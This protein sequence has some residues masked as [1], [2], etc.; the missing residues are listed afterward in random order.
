[1]NATHPILFR[2]VQR[3]RD[4]WWIMLLVFGLAALQWSIFL[5]HLLGA[6][7]GN[8]PAPLATT[9]VFWLLFGVGLPWF[10]LVLR[11]EVEVYPDA[12]A[13]RFPPLL[14]RLIAREEIAAAEPLDYRPLGEFGG[15]GIRG[16]G[17]R[18]AYNVR[19]NQGVELTL[20]DGRR[21]VIGSQ[22]PVELAAAIAA[23]RR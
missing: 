10:F 12:V 11:L 9:T 7:L 6:P 21:V 3:F 4:V 22:R 5:S 16:W 20:L 1:M 19:G 2:E 23:G 18:V 13:I 14:Q 17:R 15:W 8:N